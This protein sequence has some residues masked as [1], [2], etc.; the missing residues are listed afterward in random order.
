MLIFE[1]K[2]NPYNDRVLASV[3]LDGIHSS[4]VHDKIGCFESVTS[5]VMGQSSVNEAE[6]RCVNIQ[7]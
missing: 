1:A 4:W 5:D 2:F 3:H 7:N 6:C